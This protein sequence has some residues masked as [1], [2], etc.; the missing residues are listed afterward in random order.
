MPN[1]MRTA[2]EVS[3]DQKLREEFFNAIGQGLESDQP[4]DFEK[5]I[6]PPD[7]LFRG[8]LGQPEEKYCKDNNIPDWYSWNTSRECCCP[9]S[10]SR[11]T[12][13]PTGILGILK[14]GEP[15]GTRP[16]ARSRPLDR[17][18]VV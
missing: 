12:T 17:K 4:I 2:L 16:M 3:G 13:F 18:S 10:T 9:C 11:T 14:T 5:I 7:N 1:W 8:N 15:S 6:P